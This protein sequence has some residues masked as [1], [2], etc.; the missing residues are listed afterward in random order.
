MVEFKIA[1]GIEGSE[2]YAAV[3]AKTEVR[4]VVSFARRAEP[5]PGTPIYQ[6]TL[7]TDNPPG[8]HLDHN[9]RELPVS[10]WDTVG[11]YLGHGLVLVVTV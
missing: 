8:F 2:A 6:N 7:E 11:I 5:K 3:S 9:W 4:Y 1:D 10:A